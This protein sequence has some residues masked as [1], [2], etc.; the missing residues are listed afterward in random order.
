MLRALGPEE[1]ADMKVDGRVEVT[2]EFC[3]TRYVFG[4]ADLATLYSS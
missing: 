2:C 3:N 4:D 1:L